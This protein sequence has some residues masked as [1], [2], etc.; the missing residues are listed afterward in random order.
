MCVFSELAKMQEAVT[1]KKKLLVKT[2]K[3]LKTAAGTESKLSVQLRSTRSQV[4]EAKSAL[5]SH[6]S[7]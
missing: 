5:Q 2:E 6:K 7:R 4:E 1:D 3:D